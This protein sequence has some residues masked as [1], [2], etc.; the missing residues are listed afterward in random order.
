MQEKLNHFES[1]D[2]ADTVSEAEELIGRHNQ[3][4]DEMEN[5][6]EGI[7]KFI[8]DGRRLVEEGHSMSEE[9]ILMTAEFNRLLS[10]RDKSI[11]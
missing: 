8:R 9:V 7:S 6:G 11:S 3:H 2:L 4:R 10:I 1:G 5:R